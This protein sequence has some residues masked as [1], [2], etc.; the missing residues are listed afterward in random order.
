MQKYIILEIYASFWLFFE[1][2]T[3][4]EW[5]SLHSLS[6]GNSDFCIFFSA[7]FLKNCIFS[8]QKCYLC[9]QIAEAIFTFWI[10]RSV[11]LIALSWKP[12]KFSIRDAR[13]SEAVLRYKRGL[14]FPQ[15][16]L[17]VFS[18]PSTKGVA[19]QST[20]LFYNS[21]KGLIG[22]QQINTWKRYFF[23]Y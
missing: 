21:L 9:K 14:L 5:L 19:I 22:E 7:I 4:A 6:A 12:E 13:T 8:V 11:L 1:D 15:L 20:L 23:Y 3:M 16:H 2:I 10:K 18:G 17:K